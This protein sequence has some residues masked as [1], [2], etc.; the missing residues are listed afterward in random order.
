MTRTGYAALYCR[1]SPRPDGSYEGVED[2]EKWGREYAASK[3]PGEPVE[4]FREPGISAAN[5]DHRPEYERLRRWV[6]EGRVA[7]VWCVEQSRLERREVEWFELAAELDAAGIADVHTNRDGVVSVRSEVAGIKAVLAAGEVRKLKRRVNDRLDEL[8]AKGRP[9]GAH[10]FGY[11]HGVDGGEKT[12][13][14][15]PEE[16]EAIRF[17]VDRIL[18]G[19]SLAAVAAD[20]DG[21]G[22]RGVH[23]GKITAQAVR[24]F[25]SAPTICGRRV[26]RGRD[27]G[28]GNWEP[29]IDVETWRAVRDRLASRRVVRRADGGTYPV[30]GPGTGRTGRK[31]LLTGGIAVCGVCYAPLVGSM[32]QLRGRDPQ[33]YLLCHPNRGGKGCVGIQAEPTEAHVTAWLLDQLDRPEFLDAVGADDSDDRRRSITAALDDLDRQRGELAAMWAAGKRT[34]TEWDAAVTVLDE[35]ERQ[36][37]V[38]LAELPP[39]LAGVKLDEVRAA[40]PGM[41][42][43]ERREVIGRFVQA[44][45]VHRASGPRR[46]N[47]DRI[48][49][50]PRTRE[51]RE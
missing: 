45:V 27:V 35:R 19:W 30:P 28:Q 33:A 40:W 49:I 20:L 41:P 11:R 29:I 31:Y 43:G 32:K 22:L 42:L 39:P 15:V 10:V 4:V 26:H 1:L 5:G 23:G 50:V 3:W 36:L 37:R 12:L 13:H 46:W 2:Q 21:R 7:H 14:Q 9:A 18:A 38:D 24:G 16:A 25:L 17:A 6:V 47:P 51:G 8:A 34:S 48:E 44:V